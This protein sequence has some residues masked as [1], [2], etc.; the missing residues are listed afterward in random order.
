MK[1]MPALMLNVLKLALIFVLTFLKLLFKASYLLIR[2]RSYY[3]IKCFIESEFFI[4]LYNIYST[5]RWAIPYNKAKACMAYTL[6]ENSDL[7]RKRCI[8]AN[9][10][11]A[12]DSF[13]TEEYN[14]FKKQLTWKNKLK[15]LVIPFNY[16][17]PQEE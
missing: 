8:E 7:Y 13:N 15:A 9:Q 6:Y 16:C 3:I 5:V 1:S 10:H 11:F 14:Q 2:N 4:F 12:Q 17:T